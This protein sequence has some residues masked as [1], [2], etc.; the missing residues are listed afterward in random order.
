MAQEEFQPIIAGLRAVTDGG[1]P[2]YLM[3]GN[4]DFLIGEGFAQATGCRLLEGGYESESDRIVIAPIETL[5]LPCE[6]DERRQ[7]RRLLL[8]IDEV[9][10]WARGA[11]ELV[12]SDGSGAPQLILQPVSAPADANEVPG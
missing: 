6:G 2:L 8:A 9:V 1:T 10:F 12:L 11:D 7:E 3:H 4:R 5:G